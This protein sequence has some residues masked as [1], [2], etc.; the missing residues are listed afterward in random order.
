MTEPGPLP[1]GSS[2][3]A[4]DVIESART[5]RLRMAVIDHEYEVALDTTRDRFGRTVHAGAAAAARA[6]RD[7]AAV[8]AYATH[9][10]PHAEELL[11]VARR[12]LDE[13]PPARHL[14]GWRAVLDGLSVTTAEIRRAFDRPVTGPSA[15]RS[16]RAALWPHLTA[17]ADHGSIASNLADQHG[18]PRHRPALTME[19]QQAWTEK[20]QAAQERGEL[21]LIESWYAADGRPVTLAYLVEDDDSTVVALHGDP[22]APGWKVIGHHAHDWEAGKGLP[23]AVPPGVLR[24]DVSRFNRPVPVPE[25]SL[26]ELVRDVVEGHSAGDA[27]NAL[28]SAVQRGYHAGPMVR[29]QELL[30]TSGQFSSA[31]ETVHGRQIAA[32]LSALG[33]QVEFLAREVEDAAEDLGATVAVLP[34]HRTPIL[35]MRPRPAVDTTPP[36]PPPR[37]ST[38]TH[39]R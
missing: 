28:L 39:H 37:A 30:E 21:D 4:K 8:E 20:A 32:R 16:R 3:V 25:V 31:L 2:T 9:L 5:F 36:A 27:S 33:R 12:A 19:E 23:P 29:L 13:L 35:R 14:A 15:E 6:H 1:D 22:G 18:A 34:P 17:W 10:A 38:S 24:P 11:D 26:Q 7:E